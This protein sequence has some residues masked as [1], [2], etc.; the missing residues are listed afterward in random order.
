[1]AATIKVVLRKK[2]NKD[3]TFPLAIRITKDRKTSFIHLNHNILPKDWNVAEQKVKKSHPNSARLNNY[4]AKK[5]SEALDGALE[6]ETKKTDASA[7]AV[8]QKIKPK[9]GAT[10]FPQADDYLLNLQASGKF[11]RYSPDK[12]RIGHFREFL[13]DQDI[14]F[15]DITP[16]L[17]DKFTSF[18]RSYH[19]GKEG[20][21]PM[22]ER[23]IVN[24]L[25]VVRSVFAHAR[26]NKVI[27]KDQSPFGGDDGVKIV[28]PDSTK[29]G[30]SAEDVQ[31]LEDAELA[32]SRLDHTRNLWL[33]SF[34]FAGIRVSDLLRLR[35]S[36][37]N[38]G[39][40]HYLMGKN[41]KGG[42]LKIPV[43]AL[44]I[45]EKYKGDDT[46]EDDLVFPELKGV[47]VNDEFETQRVIA[48]KGRT[49]NQALKDIMPIAGLDGKPEMHKTRHTFGGLAGDTIPIQ[50]L[51]KLYRHTHVST[52][53]GYQKSFTYKDAD[54]ALD[55]VLSKADI[56]NLKE[57]TLE[58][59]EGT[60]QVHFKMSTE[61]VLSKADFDL[62]TDCIGGDRETDFYMEQGEFWQRNIARNKD[63][64]GS[65]FIVIADMRE[66]ATIVLRALENNYHNVKAKALS[67]RLSAILT[68]VISARDNLNKQYDR[69]S[70]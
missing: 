51:Q 53:I 59:T 18:L 67:G 33:V 4:I 12:P 43:K 5:H 63:R 20:K 11:N 17:L 13:R 41:D 40:L 48:V 10:F 57:Q 39:R 23:T 37:F 27:T 7:I 22:S 29:V 25:A 61:I 68:Q 62:I 1:M 8:R 70:F 58:A 35:W 6:I 46:H 9:V 36:D 65:N 26:R 31:K 44:A 21:K 15:T 28:F 66:L 42:S 30:L 47:D 60:F 49:I 3:G 54:D 50:M 45:L 32:D 2:E 16:G 64:D 56:K 38:N 55:A 19:K 34:Y 52:S 24:H 14:A 69:Q